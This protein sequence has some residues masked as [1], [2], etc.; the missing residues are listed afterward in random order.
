MFLMRDLFVNIFTGGRKTI[1]SETI[2]KQFLH[3]SKSFSRRKFKQTRSENRFQ[4]ISISRGISISCF[5]FGGG[6]GKY[7]VTYYD[8]IMFS[9]EISM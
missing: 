5:L 7:L 4:L 6:D 2:F 1:F 8:E 3:C 9:C